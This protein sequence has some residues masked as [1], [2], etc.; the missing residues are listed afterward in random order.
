MLAPQD[1]GAIYAQ[2]GWDAGG[3]AGAG[4]GGAGGGRST[5]R[6]I[7]HGAGAGGGRDGGE[8]W[9]ARGGAHEHLHV[10]GVQPPPG[11]TRQYATTRHGE[12]AGGMVSGVFLGG[13]R[14]CLCCLCFR[15]GG[16]GWKG[17]FLIGVLYV[18]GCLGA[19][20]FVCG[21]AG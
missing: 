10:W 1:L 21:R 9:I 3:A 19:F 11:L 16:G 6:I 7:H 18:W 15:E 20:C 5:H 2:V 12:R 13:E 14:G 17:A 4:A 8:G